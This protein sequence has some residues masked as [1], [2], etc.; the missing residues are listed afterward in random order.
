MFVD[1]HCHINFKGLADRLPAVL[2]N[3]REHDVTHALC[4]SVDFETL[5]EVLAIAEAHDN[6]Y[7]SV[8]V[9]PDHEDAREPTLAE[10]IELAAHPKV[11]AIGE[12]GLD[13][14]RLEG[15]SIADME[16]QRERFRTHIRAAHAT[17]KPL[18]IHTRSSSE[19]TLRIMAEERAA[20]PGGVMHCFTEPWPVA[21]QA[22][23]QGF[24]ISLSGIV[25]FKNATDVQDVARR[26]PLDR[27]LIETDSPYL[28]P[29]PYRGKPNEPAYV[30]HVGRFIA[31]ERGIAVEAL[32]DATTQN[33][34]RL[35]KIVR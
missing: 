1:S 4:V 28:A 19:D 23:A 18:I 9:H 22:L 14:Y 10:L 35:F 2:E 33:F 31:S 24:H 29:V 17:L 16:W 8:G 3:M 12:T 11:V 20:V 6:V 7:A 5:P 27:L 25:T 34:F 32:A 26:V 30:S 15:R 21:E 13:Y